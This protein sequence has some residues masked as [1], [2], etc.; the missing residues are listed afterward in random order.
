MKAT[1][2]N[3]TYIINPQD[4]LHYQSMG[5][6]I[7]DDDGN[8]VAYG[9]GKTVPY[10]EYAQLKADYDRLYA[11]LQEMQAGASYAELQEMRADTSTPTSGEDTPS[12][13]EKTFDDMSEEQLLA[14]AREK[15][16]NTGKATTRDG[17]LKKIEEAE[18]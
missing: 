3:K 7:T 17:I 4:Q 6:D 1:K 13:S 18:K 8:I 16:I 11:E 2:G 12:E 15:G 9:R 5:Y 10:S 14:Y